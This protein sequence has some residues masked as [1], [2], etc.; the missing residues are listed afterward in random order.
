MIYRIT[1]VDRVIERAVLGNGA[2]GR[3]MVCSRVD[4]RHLVDTSGK[5][6][7]N[8]SGKDTLDGRNV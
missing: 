1:H 2:E 5:T 7:G 3:L 4:R 6:T 8:I